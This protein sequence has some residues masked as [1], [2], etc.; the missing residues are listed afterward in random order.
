[1]F[2]LTGIKRH[3]YT[4]W[5]TIGV[6]HSSLIRMGSSSENIQGTTS[7]LLKSVDNAAL[8]S[9]CT[10]RIYTDVMSTCQKGQIVPFSSLVIFTSVEI[11]SQ[12]IQN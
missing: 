1:M 3:V 8:A 12:I 4:S 9:S 2:L 5:R 7:P 11:P 6:C 10:S